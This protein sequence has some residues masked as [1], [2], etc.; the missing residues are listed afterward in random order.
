LDRAAAVL[1]ELVEADLVPGERYDV[2]AHG[3]GNVTK[4]MLECSDAQR[5]SD[6]HLKALQAGACNPA[7]GGKTSF[8]TNIV[9]DL[10]TFEAEVAKAAGTTPTQRDPWDP[11]FE[12]RTLN[13]RLINTA[14]ATAAALVHG[15]RR[16]VTDANSVTIDLSRHS[17]LFVGSSRL[18][19]QLMDCDCT[20]V[21]CEIDM[22]DCQI[23]HLKPWAEQN[24][25]TGSGRTHP[26]NGA[27]AC[28]RH[29]RFKHNN[30]YRTIR[31]ADQWQYRPGGT[32]V[33]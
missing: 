33:Q 18:A 4:D 27:G 16:V 21:G 5:R 26:G 14:E 25:G 3:A 2:G 24:D 28:A 23:D 1:G 22:T 6:A 9:L 17:R 11:R 13:G 31:E 30:G 7:G 8:V 32:K 20:Y 10:A 19:V 12:S 15:F 29:N